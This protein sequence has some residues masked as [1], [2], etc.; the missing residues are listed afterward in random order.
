ME[1]FK[2]REGAVEL[3]NYKQAKRKEDA[4]GKGGWGLVVGK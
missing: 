4:I 3:V 1:N 2:N